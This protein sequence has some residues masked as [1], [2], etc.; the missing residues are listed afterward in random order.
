MD[1]KRCIYCGKITEKT[2]YAIKAGN[3]EGN[4]FYCCSISCYQNMKRFIEENTAKKN[5]FYVA[6]GIMVLANLVIFGYHLDFRWM[7]LPM[8]G[9]G[10][11][12]ALCPSLYVTNYFYGKFG[13]VK[14]VKLIRM[15]GFAFSFMG[16]LFTLLWK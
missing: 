8:I 2:K 15:F 7:Y 10:L 5:I 3:N 9:L 12:V 16:V 6:A 1:Q 13:I 14:T 4:E 11:V